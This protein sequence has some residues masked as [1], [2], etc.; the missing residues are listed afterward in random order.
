MISFFSVFFSLD[1]SKYCIWRVILRV[2]WV[3]HGR[4][5]WE[6]VLLF[7]VVE[8]EVVRIVW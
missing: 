6:F 1:F 8:M 7:C 5:Y 3:G 2:A 4:D